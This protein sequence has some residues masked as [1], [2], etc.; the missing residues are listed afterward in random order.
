MKY[1]ILIEKG[2]QSWGAQVPDLPGC[3]AVGDSR[4]EVLYLIRDAIS[5]HLEALQK[6]GSPVPDGALQADTIEIEIP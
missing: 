6:D 1:T 3:V 4:E 5:L 2:E